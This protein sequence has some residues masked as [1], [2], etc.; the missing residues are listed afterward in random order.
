MTGEDFRSRY[1]VGER[2]TEPPVVTHRALDALGSPVLVHYLLGST[3]V[4]SASI[5]ERVTRAG[6]EF[7]DEIRGIEEVDGIQ[8]VV[9]RV[10][11]GF[12]TF[13]SW[14]GQAAP[15]DEAPGPEESPAPGAYTQLFRTSDLPPGSD[16]NAPRPTTAETVTGAG[17]DPEEEAPRGVPE[18]APSERDTP[19]PIKSDAPPA[20]SEE[21]P[22]S[23]TG[24]FGASA[25]ADPTPPLGSEKE[26]DTGPAETTPPPMVGPP[27]KPKPEAEEAP[28]SYTMLFGSD[29]AGLAEPSEPEAPPPPPPPP[30]AL[31]LPELPQTRD[32]VSTTDLLGEGV[33]R[34]EEEESPPPVFPT[35]TSLRVEPPSDAG[36]QDLP[37]ATNGDASAGTPTDQPSAPETPPAPTSRPDQ[38]K[39]DQ[40]GA[41]TQIFGG[42]QP[43]APPPS[44]QPPPYSPPPPPPPPQTPQQPAVGSQASPDWRRWKDTPGASGGHIPSDN[45]LEHLNGPVDP[46]SGPPTP[47]S[48]GPQANAVPDPLFSGSGSPGSGGVGGGPG[49]YTMVREGLST[50]PIPGSPGG[51]PAVQSPT[52]AAPEEARTEGPR[53]EKPVL[54]IVGLVAIVLVIVALVVVF[55]VVG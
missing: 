19:S 13:L 2:I 10:I 20:S 5:L 25:A 27:S 17:L 44:H 29:T 52:P 41:Y 23:Y 1:Q 8:V 50:G 30:A 34:K 37:V 49:H 42:I 33:S 47:S 31:P 54:A 3:E 24:L 32:E 21:T 55:A 43:G 46:G 9:T 14:L 18:A 12:S 51:P 36:P 28:G 4:S 22:G 38:S 48:S 11:A 26:K 39:P 35:L 16:A 45:Y 53:Q 6:P 40:P 15:S 7:Q